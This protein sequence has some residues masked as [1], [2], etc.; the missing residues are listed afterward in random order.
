MRWGV[1]LGLV[2]V[3]VSFAGSGMSVY[4]VLATE[5]TPLHISGS[6]STFPKG[7]YAA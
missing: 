5:Y 1:H 3:V 7:Y 2:S 4:T 6:Y